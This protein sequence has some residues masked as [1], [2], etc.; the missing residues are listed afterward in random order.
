MPFSA[1]RNI[2]ALPPSDA[3]FQAELH[4]V[5]GLRAFTTAGMAINPAAAPAL[6]LSRN[7]ASKRISTKPWTTLLQGADVVRGG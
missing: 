6:D 1:A 4:G 2:G 7:A 5:R 3:E